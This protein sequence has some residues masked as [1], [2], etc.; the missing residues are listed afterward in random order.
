MKVKNWMTRNIIT[1]TPDTSLMQAIELMRTNSI[2]HLPVTQEREIY[3]LV[4]ESNLRQYFLSEIL[5]EL[6]VS[7]VMIMNPIT[8]D[9]NATLD[10]AARLIYKYKIG[11]LPVLEKR[12]L[13]G[14]ITNTDIVAAF[15]EFLGLLDKSARL[16]VMI[17]EN[18][19][20]ED[21]LRIIRELGGKI[22]SVVADAQ[23]TRKRVHCIRLERCELDKIIEALEKQNHKV[24]SILE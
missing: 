12:K 21:V 6:K 24:L 23:A 13:V 16:D 8:I 5:P 17:A 3:G 15:I 20:L 11:G 18:G 1:V 14:I 10:A 4:T 2:R 7:D 9:A 19:T 22:I